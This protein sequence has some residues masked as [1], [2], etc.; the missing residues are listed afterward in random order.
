MPFYPQVKRGVEK[1]ASKM[2]NQIEKGFFFKQEIG[3]KN[4]DL[5]Q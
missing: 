1:Q 2:R 3:G 5:C 4:E